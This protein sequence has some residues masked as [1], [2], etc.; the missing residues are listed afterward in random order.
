MLSHLGNRILLTTLLLAPIAR[1]QTTEPP[2]LSYR[3][4]HRFLEQ[5][6]W[7][8]DADSIARL[9]KLGYTQYLEEQFAATP[10][11]ISAVTPDAN[12]RQLLG[13]MQQEFYSNAVHGPD[14]LRQ[15]VAFA[16]GQIWVVSGVRLTDASQLAP[17]LRLLSADAF[18]N[19]RKLMADVTLSPAMGRYLDMVNNDKPNPARGT[20]ANENYARELLQLFTIGLNQFEPRWHAE[21]G[22]SR[23]AHRH[24]RTGNHRRTGPRAH[25]L[26]VRPHARRRGEVA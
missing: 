19:Y 16:L 2:A 6:S 11:T 13:P 23:T 17:W 22:C 26:D 21:A 24:L 15:R 14:Q 4:A 3:A 25:R 5:A 10:S 9:E 1:A 18:S 7:G 20:A 8:P 12:G